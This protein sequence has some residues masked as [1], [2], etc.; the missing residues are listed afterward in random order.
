M[1]H[2]REY[3][4]QFLGLKDGEHEF[5]FQVGLEF[6]SS[7]ND[8]DA[9]DA[10][11]IAQI[12]LSK[13]PEMLEMH[14]RVDGR[15]SVACDRCD[16]PL[17]IDLS[18]QQ[19]QVFKVSEREEYDNEEIV[20]ISATDHEIDVSEYIYECIKLALPIRRVHKKK[21]CDPVAIEALE[22]VSRNEEPESD[23][24]WEALKAL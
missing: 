1:E 9:L 18:G 24:R 2:S 16:K 17:N 20:A 7:F 22:A 15:V 10:N 5:D 11:L 14:L 6:L 8:D 13:K 21:N 12:T 3:I 4:I 23:P 19:R